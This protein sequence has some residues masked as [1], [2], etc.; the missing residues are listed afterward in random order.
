MKITLF[1]LSILLTGCWTTCHETEYQTESCTLVPDSG[2]CDAAMPR[3]YYDQSEKK[4]KEF[5]WGGCG[6]VVPFETLEECKI[7][8]QS[9]DHY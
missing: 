2:L 8:E 5:M 9:T 6:G 1:L 3:Y 7:C 4:C